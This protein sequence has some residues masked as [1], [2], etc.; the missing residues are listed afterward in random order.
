MSSVSEVLRSLPPEAP[1]V[2]LPPEPQLAPSP[3][4]SSSSLLG[5]GGSP[6]EMPPS[7]R[8]SWPFGHGP[9][10][11]TQTPQLCARLLD[12]PHAPTLSLTSHPGL[13]R[14]PEQCP[15]ASGTPPLLW[16]G[17]LPGPLGSCRLSWRPGLSPACSGE[18]T[19][20]P[21]LVQSQS[22]QQESQ[23]PPPRPRHGEVSLSVLES[24]CRSGLCAPSPQK[25]CKGLLLSPA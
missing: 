19:L 17:L 18:G 12:S 25:S 1:T 11:P 8:P 7:S 23:P 21:C 5:T 3:S 4:L 2:V 9:G 14:R 24:F 6:P 13:W 16:N 10:P 15:G 22:L 20:A